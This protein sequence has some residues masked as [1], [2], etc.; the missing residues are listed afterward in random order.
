[1]RGSAENARRFHDPRLADADGASA[2]VAQQWDEA[3][4]RE[5]Y[6]WLFE[7]DVDAVLV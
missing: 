1:M 2:Y 5:R 4:V 3:R 6:Q 7:Y